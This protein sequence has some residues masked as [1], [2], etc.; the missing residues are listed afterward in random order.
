MF[1]KTENLKLKTGQTKFYTFSFIVPSEATN[2]YYLYAEA[3]PPDGTAISAPVGPANI[4]P[5][6]VDLSL[7]NLANPVAIVQGSKT[8][9]KVTFNIANGGNVLAKGKATLTLFAST[10][11]TTTG[12]VEL[13]ALQVAISLKPGTNKTFSVSPIVPGGTVAAGN[14]T[15][16]GVLT[17]RWQ[18]RMSLRG[19]WGIIRISA[20][21]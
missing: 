20:R 11:G 12:E 3:I 19:I 9:P 5:A 13:G 10:T 21:G 1:N 4:A 18:G 17:V 14:Y 6:F 7:T 8:K 16:I 15:L 2:N